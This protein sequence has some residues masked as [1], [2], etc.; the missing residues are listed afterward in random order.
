MRL[1][2]RNQWQFNA[3]PTATRTLHTYTPILAFIPKEHQAA[4]R[5]LLGQVIAS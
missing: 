2:L 1:G 5:K 4:P 3:L